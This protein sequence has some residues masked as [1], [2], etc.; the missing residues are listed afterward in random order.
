MTDRC[1]Y[2]GWRQAHR[3]IANDLRTALRPSP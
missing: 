2:G 3:K 1:G